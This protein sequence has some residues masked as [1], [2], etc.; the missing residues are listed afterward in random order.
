MKQR[1]LEGAAAA[2]DSGAQAD[3]E[4]LQQLHAKIGCQAMEIETLKKHRNQ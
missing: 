1:F 3:K 4:V 2:F